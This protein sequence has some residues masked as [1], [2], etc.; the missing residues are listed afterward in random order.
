M[1]FLQSICLIS[2]VRIIIWLYKD[3]LAHGINHIKKIST[4]NFPKCPEEKPYLGK[5]VQLSHM[6]AKMK[7]NVIFNSRTVRCL[8]ALHKKLILEVIKVEL[9]HNMNCTLSLSCAYYHFTI[10]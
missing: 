2:A 8:T 4:L 6:L 9:M 3:T 1:I 7:E 10:E 5:R